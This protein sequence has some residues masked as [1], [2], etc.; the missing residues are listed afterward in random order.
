MDERSEANLVGV[1]PFLVAIVRG[2]HAM[3]LD[4]SPGLAF[5]VI[6]GVRNLDRQRALVA[7]GASR[8]MNSYHLMR[9]TKQGTFGLAVDL[10]AEIEGLGARWDWPLYPRIARRMKAAA[11]Q[12]GHRITWGGDWDGDNSSANE[13]FRDGPHFQLEGV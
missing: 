1:H 12:L 8:T 6:E 4:D 9:I 7:A 13:S 5:M 2:A 10:L 11:E 3:M